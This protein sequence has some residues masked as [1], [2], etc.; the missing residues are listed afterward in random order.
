MTHICNHEAAPRVESSTVCRD[1]GWPLEADW[2]HVLGKKDGISF[3]APFPRREEAQAYADSLEG[4]E[5]E[6]KEVWPE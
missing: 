4:W 5:C 6:V 1:C 3:T 2:F